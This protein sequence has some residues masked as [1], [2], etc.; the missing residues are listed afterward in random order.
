MKRTAFI[1]ATLCTIAVCFS[2]CKEKKF[3]GYEQTETGLYYKFKE[4]NPEG[5][6]AQ[7]GDFLYMTV[8]YYS[9]NDSLPKFESREIM[10][11]MSESLYKGDL[12]EAYSLLKEGEEG[13]FV[14]Q[15]D[16]FFYYFMR[17]IPPNV[18]SEDVLYFTIRM[19][20]VKT[21]ADFE[22][23]E[24]VAIKEYVTENNITAEPTESGLYYIETVKGKGKKAE[25][26]D[27]VRVHYTGKFLDGTVFDASVGNGKN[28]PLSFVLGVNPMIEGFVEGVS[29]M[30]K[31]GK[32][33]LILPFNIAYGMSHPMSAIPPFTPLVF[34]V[35][36]VDV[37]IIKN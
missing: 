27:S 14:L 16:S 3:K 5:K 29:L 22:E 17:Q 18:T 23:E 10:D 35:E 7:K 32:A 30:N 11:V 25:M 1:V 8:S 33:T 36:L 26:G 20:K 21:M 4:R 6:Q 2:A 12:Y 31:G 19:D 13:E 24:E 9:S 37:I 15:A 34:D 28:E